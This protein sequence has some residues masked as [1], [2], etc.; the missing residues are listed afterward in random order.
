MLKLEDYNKGLICTDITNCID[1]NKCI[2]ECPILKSNVSVMGRNGYYSMCVDEKECILCGTCLDTCVHGAR[3]Y[4]DDCGGFLSDLEL[5][6]NFSVIVAPSFYLNYPTDSKHILGYLKSLGVKNFYSATI[7]A[8]ISTWGYISHLLETRSVGNI[9]QPCPTIV[10]H[11]EKHQPNL[12][13]KLVPIQSPMMCTAIYLKHY[14]GITEELAFLGPCIAKKIEIESPRGMGLIKH[15]ITFK[16][17]SEHIK[18]H[19]IDLGSFSAAELED[20]QGVSALYPTP[21]GLR[22]NIEFH[23][24]AEAS[25]MHIDGERRVYE[26]LNFLANSADEQAAPTPALIDLLNCGRG[27]SYGTGSEFRKSDNYNA[28]YQAAAIRGRRLAVSD[29]YNRDIPIHPADRLKHLNERFKSLNLDDFKCEY[30]ADTS[31]PSISI[32]EF[33]INSILDE[34]LYKLTEN[35]KHIDCSACGYKTCREM[36]EAI[37]LGINHNNNCVYYVK[38]SLAEN[39]QVMEQRLKAMLDAS[40]VLCAIFDDNLEITEVNQEAANILKLNDKNEYISKFFELSPEFQPDGMLSRE[41]VLLYVK[42]ALQTGNAF[43][44]EWMHVTLSGELVPVEVHLKRVKL[45]GKFVVIVYA[46]DL[47]EQK[48]MQS[49]LEASLLREQAANMAKTKF[50]SNMSH[51]I[52]TPMNSV[53]GISELQLRKDIHPPETEE[54][55]ARIYSAS[56]LLLTIINDILDLSRVEAGKMEIIPAPYDTASLIVDTVQLNLMSIGSKRIDFKL[57]VDENL[58]ESLIG[59]EVRVKQIL[60]NIVSNAFKYTME[61]F[62]NLSISI[63]ELSSPGETTMVI[64]V[65]DSGQGMTQ[66]QI[67]SL[68]GDVYT[69]FNQ[70]RNRSIEGSGLGLVIAGELINMMGGDISVKSRQGKGSTFTVTLP[71]KKSND[72]VLGPVVKARLENLRDTQVAL[73]K[74]SKFHREPMP[75]GRVLVVDDVESNLYVAKGFLMPYKI[76]VDTAGSGAQAIAKIKQG[77]VYDI[78]FMDH[79]MPQLDGIETTKILRSMGYDNPI[80]ALTANALSDSVQLFTENNFS[81]YISKP[82][83]IALLDKYLI[84]YIRDKQPPY[85][86]SH[87]RAKSGSHFDMDSDVELSNMLIESFL[88]DAETSIIRLGSF[89]MQQEVDEDALNTYTIH[90]HAMKSALLNIGKPLLSKK[91]AVLEDAGRGAKI[92]VIHFETPRFLE[93]LR[94]LVKELKIRQESGLTDL[95]DDPDFLRGHLLTIKTACDDFDVESAD[96]AL[97]KLS[98]NI[99]SRQTKTL[100][101]TIADHLLCCE[102]EEASELISQ[103]I[104]NTEP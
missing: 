97:E 74:I 83:D 25:V 57:T 69:R 72:A 79:M 62:V 30:R 12:M 60:N 67:N 44:P 81:G 50:L 102:F 61:G 87:A 65:E 21:G 85:V 101:N 100:I 52:R 3:H 84:R 31:F 86:I 15:N 46:R 42:K 78:I 1:C 54:A 92:E 32:S 99:S 17:L 14:R 90:A 23:M 68:F 73:K 89:L 58:P 55:F 63:Q 34:Q 104:D 88:R 33:E 18:A 53:L 80:I 38:N 27:C 76:S 2:H 96:K 16:S 71:H 41:K 20:S 66:T 29:K 10:R 13:G 36:A 22:E 51:E 77:Q 43:L 45:G 40:P 19:N 24:G 28:A 94:E 47:R 59:D 5:G 11:I 7:G 37:A 91:A 39:T 95:D 35:D 56:N 6:R 49:E 9:A 82:I 48:E 98:R 75:Y 70:G 26:C 4:K 64:T 93:R 8:D 103:T